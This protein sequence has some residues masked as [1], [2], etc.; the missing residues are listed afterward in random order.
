MGFDGCWNLLF[1]ELWKNIMDDQVKV[2][3]KCSSCGHEH[4][5]ICKMCH[6]CGCVRFSVERERRKG[7]FGRRKDK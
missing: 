7:L 6:K 4:C 5:L 3:V 2:G 1:K